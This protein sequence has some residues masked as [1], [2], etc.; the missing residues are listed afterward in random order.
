[1]VE[2]SDQLKLLSD[3]TLFHIGLYATLI[4]ALSSLAQFGR[5]RVSPPLI[6]CAAFTV[7]CFLVAGAAG[8]AIAS[9]IPNYARFADY[10]AANL[11]VF[12]IPSLTY[13]TWAHVEH[14]A[15]WLGIVVFVGGILRGI[16][17][18]D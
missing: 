18:E 14:G 6:K 8:G 11:N 12:G 3:Y 15:F 7:A 5:A 9:N 10:D 2:A 16:G 17:D 4:T 13:Q 1:M